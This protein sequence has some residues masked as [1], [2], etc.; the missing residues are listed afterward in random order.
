MHENLKAHELADVLK[1]AERTVNHWRRE[2]IIPFS[3]F[4]PKTIRYSLPDV[5]D[6]L[7]A[8]QARKVAGPTAQVAR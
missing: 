1:V 4:G 7:K 8:H 5:L 2:G 3:Q 6:A